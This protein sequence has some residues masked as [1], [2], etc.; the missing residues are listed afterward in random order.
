MVYLKNWNA[1]AN[2]EVLTNQ[3]A[4]SENKTAHGTNM[5]IAWKCHKRTPNAKEVLKGHVET[6]MQPSPRVTIAWDCPKWT[7]H[8]LRSKTLRLHGL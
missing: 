3:L 1:F 4:R 8:T 5:F 6:L 7:A 2:T